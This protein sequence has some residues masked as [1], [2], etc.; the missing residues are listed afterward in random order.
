MRKT[1][2]LLTDQDWKSLLSRATEKSYKN[3]DLIIAEGSVQS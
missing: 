3:N 2:A 1:F